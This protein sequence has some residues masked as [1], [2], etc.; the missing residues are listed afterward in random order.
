MAEKPFDEVYFVNYNQYNDIRLYEVGIHN[1][2]PK[3]GYGPTVRNTYIMHY[4]ISGEGRLTLHGKTYS[5]HE[6]QIFVIPP[7]ELGYYEAD[8]ETPWHYIW[9]LIDGKK[10]KELF[11]KV[12]ITLHS[13][14]YTPTAHHKEIEECM[15]NILHYE[16]KQYFCIG[17][18]YHL[19]QLMIDN[20]PSPETQKKSGK[21]S[22]SHYVQDIIHYVEQKY[23]EPITIQDICSYC[24]LSRSY[25]ARIFKRHTDISIQEYLINY[26][27][28]K[29]QGLL[30][31]TQIP[32]HHISC[33]VGYQDAF[34]FSRVFKQKTGLSPSQYRE[35]QIIH[36]PL[37]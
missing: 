23:S 20:G 9:I 14:I 28:R 2:P 24:G 32:I 13:P 26:R 5:I 18:L 36:D 22:T 15:M 25:L 33:L 8:K 7:N 35:Q 37:P 6:N 4:I 34:T 29:A 3:Y 27:I 10:V 19:F 1:C 30:H 31:T 17:N 12:G 21:E 11:K 16:K